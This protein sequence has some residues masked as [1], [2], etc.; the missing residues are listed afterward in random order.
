MR[1][2]RVV[3]YTSLS[4]LKSTAHYE[5]FG[6]IT[7]E[8]YIIKI[9]VFFFAGNLHGPDLR[10]YRVQEINGK[11]HFLL[12]FKKKIFFIK[13]FFVSHQFRLPPT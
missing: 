9:L 4:I 6:T 7:I 11:T 8:I 1:L 5:G 10:S 12:E 3:C 2:S 13:C